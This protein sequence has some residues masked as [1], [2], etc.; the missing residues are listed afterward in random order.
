MFGFV[1]VHL[2]VKSNNI[3][4]ILNLLKDLR[5]VVLASKEILEL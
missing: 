5:C 2:K 4:S 1:S 3:Y